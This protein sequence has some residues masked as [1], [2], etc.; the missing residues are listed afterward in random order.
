MR[1][2]KL[3][4]EEKVERAKVE[5]TSESPFF[6]YLVLNAR[7]EPNEGMGALAR[8]GPDGLGEYDPEMVDELSV[9][10]VKG[11]IAHEALH[12]ALQHPW[13]ETPEHFDRR[14][15]ED[16]EEIEVNGIIG[17]ETGYDLPDTEFLPEDGDTFRFA[18]KDQDDIIIENSTE[19]DLYSIYQELYEQVD[20]DQDQEDDPVGQERQE[21]DEG[22]DGSQGS[23]G[24][25]EGQDSE[26]EEDQAQ[27]QQDK[28]QQDK[29]QQS[30]EADN[31]GQD[32]SP[33]D[34]FD[35]HDHGSG[36]E[37][38]E[39]EEEVKGEWEKAL[40][41]AVQQSIAAGNQPAGVQEK[42]EALMGHDVSWRNEL[43][44]YV[45]EQI[46][47]GFTYERPSPVS[48]VAGVYLADVEYEESIKVVASV[49]TSGSVSS[50]VLSQFKGDL[51]DMSNSYE[52]VDIT[53][54]SHDTE[55]HDSLELANS[56][57]SDIVDWNP[58]GR[59]GTDLKEPFRY[60]ERE[61]MDCD[62]MIELTDGQAV[63]P[64]EPPRFPVLWVLAGN[65]IA[66]ESIKFGR[67]IE[68]D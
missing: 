37:N 22:S 68:A 57:P 65:H 9:D 15:L 39:R 7:F 30:D 59:G 2:S 34:G 18:M 21:R 61:I 16:A 33:R 40:S 55:V 51:A 10:E 38:S 12:L 60:A 47:S 6:S 28:G 50:K 27:E 14:I 54:L 52:Q 45:K 41:K 31:Q 11:L 5:I 44:H 8:V 36:E 25:E 48:R 3:T 64:E 32:E 17:K 24:G 29:E 26:D 49:D 58:T 35:I 4:V 66:P 42:L 43:E 67:V 62:I 63:L 13:L 1:E 46:P 53:I 19:K 20:E 23:G 56:R